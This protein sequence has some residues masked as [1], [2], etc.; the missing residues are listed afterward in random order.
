MIQKGKL[1]K[2]GDYGLEK[3]F[4]RG[5][6]SREDTNEGNMINTEVA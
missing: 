3:A 5:N 4:D 1:F 2:G 6:D